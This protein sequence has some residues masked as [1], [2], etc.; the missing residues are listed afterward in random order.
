[1]RTSN[2]QHKS[3]KSSRATRQRVWTAGLINLRTDCQGKQSVLHLEMSRNKLGSAVESSW[4]WSRAGCAQ[5]IWWLTLW[6]TE[7]LTGR[8]NGWFLINLC[9]LRGILWLQTVLIS[10][11]WEPSGR[12]WFFR[13]ISCSPPPPCLAERQLA[14]FLIPCSSCVFAW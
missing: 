8:S 6:H 2:W 12:T 1:M 13:H 5:H 4:G 14:V 3:D 10:I 7:G 11:S 9:F